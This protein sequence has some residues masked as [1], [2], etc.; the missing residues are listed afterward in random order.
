MQFKR[1][2]INEA[3]DQAK[4]VFAYYGFKYPAWGDWSPAQWE[5]AGPEYDEIRDCMLG[6]DV[7]DFGS[8]DFYEI[9]RTIFTLRNGSANNPG[10]RKNYAEKLFLNLENQRAP[11]HFHFSKMED[12][13]CQ[14]GGNIIVQLTNTTADHQPSDTPVQVSVDGVLTEVP[15]G[16]EV[17]LKPGM[18]VNIAPGIIHQFWAE[19]GSGVTV[20]TEVSSVCDDRHDNCFLEHSARFP[21]IIEDEKPT[22]CL[23][24]EYP[25]PRVEQAS[26]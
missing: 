5:Q 1:S 3:I 4:E 16:G 19:A 10:Y 6:W 20:S 21:E 7:T 26:R 13:C 18:S 15:A 25:R 17:R 12:I 8:N 24:H 2:L 14:A 9:G 11:A 23:V 22:H